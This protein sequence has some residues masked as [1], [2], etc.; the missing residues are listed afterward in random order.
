M[1][2]EVLKHLPLGS[3]IIWAS[4]VIYQLYRR[5][6]RT[7]TEISFIMGSFCW[8]GYAAAD[9]FIFQEAN[10]GTA[11]VLA[12]VSMSFVTLAAFFLLLFTKLFLTRP[13]RTDV[14]LLIPAVVALGL[15]WNGLVIDI[16]GGVPWNWTGVFNPS[17][18]IIWLGYIFLYAILSIRYVYRTYQVVRQTSGFLGRRMFG[19]FVSFFSAMALGMLT[20]A[21]FGALDWEIMPLFSSLLVAPAIITLYVLVPLTKERISTVMK[22]WKA[23]Q[24]QVLGVYLIYENGT[25]IAAKTPMVDREVD[26]DI[27]GATL[28]AIQT[29]MRTSFP[30]LLGKQLRRIEHGDVRILIER[31]RHSYIAVVIQGED[32]DTLWIMMKEAVQRFET[33]NEVR[34]SDWSGVVDDL[35]LV[36][37]TLS[38]LFREKSLFV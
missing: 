37:E 14:L 21:I 13:S 10:Y 23:A 20:N 12:R 31:G 30:L 19:I 8:A 18:F 5:R 35:A 2:Y 33:G 3:L 25:L 6:L 17:L 29:F 11:L 38:D 22:W 28:D 27:F 36:D 34:L 1:V 7:L 24:Y 26:E 9:W 15:V 32:T 4:I 16:R